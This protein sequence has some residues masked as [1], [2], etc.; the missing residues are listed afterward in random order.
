MTAPNCTGNSDKK[1]CCPEHR[2]CCVRQLCPQSGRKPQWASLPG[3]VLPDPSACRFSSLRLTWCTGARP[4]SSTRCVR[5]MSTCFLPMPV[6]ACEY[7][8]LPEPRAPEWEGVWL[9]G[10]PRWHSPGQP[11]LHLDQ[12]PGLC[13]AKVPVLAWSSTTGPSLGLCFSS[14]CLQP[15]GRACTCHVYSQ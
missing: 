4:S 13:H 10:P 11:G 9:A 6:C 15:P 2:K 5:T 14:Q 7:L 8:W 3:T 1:A 12:M